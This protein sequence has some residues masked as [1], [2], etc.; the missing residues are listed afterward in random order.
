MMQI[1]LLHSSLLTIL[2]LLLSACCRAVAPDPVYALCRHALSSSAP[3]GSFV[4]GLNALLLLLRLG[5]DVEWKG[6]LQRKELDDHSSAVLLRV[7]W[8]RNINEG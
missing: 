8:I 7:G 4:I 3:S 2:T 6:L 1:N 5:E